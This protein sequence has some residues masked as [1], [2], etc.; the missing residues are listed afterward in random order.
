[1]LPALPTLT[2]LIVVAF[3]SGIG[4]TAVGPG[5]IFLTI[6]LFALTAFPSETVAGTAMTTFVA[7]GLLGSYTYY[8]SGELRTGTGRRLSVLV[9]VPSVVGA[10]V[11]AVVNSI[12][13]DAAFGVL[14]SVFTALVGATVVYRQ[15]R[16]LAAYRSPSP[17]SIAG[18]VVFGVLGFVIG[19][20]GGLLGIG[21]PVVAVPLLVVLGVSMLDALA[22]AQVQSVFL[23]AFAAA[24]YVA[25]GAVSIPLAV[26]AGVPE[27]AGVVVGWRV[28]Q[29]VDPDR[30]KVALG[31]VLV[32]AGVLLGVT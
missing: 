1:M 10:V 30:L 21:G 15:R 3:L 28:A 23:S 5:G 26:A 19:V 27:L 31:I 4:I 32:V 12:L 2:L 18:A 20:L 25:Q 22:A 6:A 24:A 7:T 13:S 11:G 9:T 29:R 16:S 14:L 17:E 8:R